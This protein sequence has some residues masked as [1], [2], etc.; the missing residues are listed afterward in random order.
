MHEIFTPPF[1]RLLKS[2]FFS[3]LLLSDFSA[4]NAQNA[5]RFNNWYF[6]NNAGVSFATG[7]PVALTNG[8]LVTTEGC[9]S[10]S[11][12]NGNL[13][14]YTDGVTV[15]NRNHVAMTNGTGL[16]GHASTTQSAIIVQRPGSTNLYYI[17]TA[18]ADAGVNGIKYSEVN[19]TLSGGLGAVTANKNIALRTP[20]SEKLTAVR[21]CNNTDLWIVSHDWNSNNF[22]TWLVT[23][24][25][26]NTTPIVS[27]AGVMA[28]GVSQGSYGQLKANPDGNKLLACYYGL[29]SGGVNRME[30]YDFNNSTGVVSNALTLASDVGLYG[31][32]FSPNGRMVYGG[33]NQG[34]LLQFNL[35]A[36]SN[37]AI[38]ASRFVLGNLGPFIGSMQLGPDNKVYV[39][40]NQTSLSVINNP[41]TAGAGCGYSNASISLAGRSSRM[42]LPN[43]ASF[44]IRPDVLTFTTAANCLDVNFTAPSVATSTNSCSGAASAIQ[45]VQ[46]NFGDPASGASNTSTAL[47]PSHTFSSM[48]A[49][50]VRLV[51]NLGCYNDT[52]IQTVNVSGFT[53]NTSTTPA[54][55]G[56]SNGTATASPAVAG[57]YTYLWSNGQQTAT[58]TGL[59]AGN[60]SCSVTASSGCISTVNVTVTA[61]GTMNV[62]VN[63]TNAACFGGNGSA[64]ASASGGTAPYSYSWSN[65]ANGATATLPA[66]NY[67]VTVS[68]AAGCV[69]NQNVTITAPAQLS[70]A[71]T[72]NSPLCSG[73]SGSAS[74]AVSGG[75]APYSYAWSNGSI[76]SSINLLTTG[77]Y[78]VTV[79]DARGCTASSSGTITIPTAL[80]ATLSTSNPWC[81]GGSNG[82]ASVSVNGGTSPYS[83][84]WSTGA[85]G[86]SIINQPAGAVLVSITDA[87]GC[88]IV[89]NGTLTAPAQ[90]QASVSVTPPACGQS[91]GSASASASGGSAPYT[92]VWSTG[93]F[94]NQLNGIAA[95]NYSLTVTDNAGC[96]DIENFS[97]S[98]SA[99]PS[100]TLTVTQQVSC[101]GGNNGEAQVS[102]NGGTAPYTYQWSNGASSATAQ[103]LS[104]GNYS[105]TIEDANGCAASANISISEPSEFQISLSSTNI[106]CNGL[107]NGTAAVT[108]NG[109]T[110]PYSF[111][112]NNSETT[113][114]ISG[115]P[116][117]VYSVIA[118]DAAGCVSKDSVSIVE[119]TPLQVL[120][121]STQITCNGASNGTVLLTISGA[122]APYSVIWNDG[123]NQLQRSGLD[124]GQY[125]YTVSDAVGCEQSG[126]ELITEPNLLSVSGI[127]A[128]LRCYGSNDGSIELQI[129]GGTQP[130]AVN[131]NSGQTT[132]TIANLDNGN[133]SAAI[134][135]ASGCEV[136]Y[137]VTI[138]EPEIIAFTSEVTPSSCIT[139]DGSIS[140]TATGGTAPYEY[141][142][143]G[144]PYQAAS[145]FNNLTA[146]NHSIS[147]RDA[148]GCELEE[149]VVVPSPAN[150]SLTVVQTTDVTCPGA[151]DG[152]AELE[153][154]GGTAPFMIS[155]SSEEATLTASM[156]SAGTHYVTVTDAAGCD[157]TTTFEIGEPQP[158]LATAAITDVRCFGG[159]DGA[160]ALNLEGGTGAIQISWEN[161]SNAAQINALAAG[162][163]A[164]E[165]TDANGC[166]VRDTFSVNQPLQA[167]AVAADIIAPGCG[168]DG[169]TIAL[170]V[171]GGTAPYTYAWSHDANLNGPLAGNLPVG[172]YS[173]TIEDANQCS[174]NDFY[175][176]ESP[177][178]LTAQIDS[179]F[180]VSCFGGNDGEVFMTVSG[181]T[182]PYLYN[183]G[184]GDQSEISTLAAGTYTMEISDAAGCEQV[185]NFNIS[186]PIA[187]LVALS[188]EDASCYGV[189]DGRVLA[190]VQGGAQP[191]AYDWS[192]NISLA[193]NENLAAGTYS[194]VVSDANG[195][196]AEAT[197]VVNQPD[198]LLVA[199][200]SENPG[201][202]SNNTG[203]ITASVSGGTGFYTYLW[204]TGSTSN[205]IAGLSSGT[206]EVQVSDANACSAQA[207]VT[208]VSGAAFSVF[209]DG[210]TS[211]CK[212][213]LTVLTATS[214]LPHTGYSISWGHGVNTENVEVN[215][216]DDELFTVV[217]TDSLGCSASASAMVHV[218]PIPAI[219]IA[220][221][222]ME[223]CAPVCTKF[224]APVGAEVYNWTFT[225]GRT[226]QGVDPTLCFENAGIYGVSLSVIDSNGCAAQMTWSETIEVF[227][228]PVA[229]FTANPSDV[230]LDDP[231]VNF[232]SQ[233]AGAVSY[234]Y[235][236]GD[237]ANNYVMSP[238][239]QHAYSDTGSFEVTLLVTNEHG[240]KDDAMRTI[241]VGGF[242]AFYIPNAFSPDGDGTNDVFMPKASGLASNG[243][244]MQIFDRWGNLIFVS[245]DWDKGWDGTYL[246]KEVQ[247]GQ[248]VCKVRYF[249]PK[250]EPTDQIGSVILT[251]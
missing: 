250:G 223:G 230:S 5:A 35:C 13:L 27:A 45:S 217:F 171:I 33:T 181:G 56:A 30:A 150:L 159:N 245:T 97:I 59:A 229:A 115:L 142:I 228:T 23:S 4:L 222:V 183:W 155:W 148:A 202:N 129:E 137:A 186:Q 60:Y 157:F 91:N 246:G 78:S 110:S 134:E 169:G 125:A 141:S 163:F 112:W 154:N 133:Y 72:A 12:L 149:I 7:S 184:V 241:H 10:I 108:A 213:E 214:N 62:N 38:V 206:Y 168:I 28:T 199:L 75:T 40:R 106:T 215:P 198:A 156:L 3:F 32:E 182:A 190:D 128:N 238:T 212:G 89:R 123:N 240:C 192:N 29:S 90:V 203:S 85:I 139:S 39:A 176:L 69:A 120:S 96:S 178:P 37:A 61:G 20:S 140:L 166:L 63:A 208:L 41:N 73:S 124:A 1:F 66:G 247:S 235:Y 79:T 55:C 98:A 175:T 160:I 187:L 65:G 109:G 57:A 36:V 144:L 248:Y 130:Y 193:I 239:A 225:D 113:S 86:T 83:Y 6:G 231:M 126:S 151:Y 173:I 197:T 82:S 116:A 2:L 172:A 58:A 48:G 146:G 162:A 54:S 9:A 100:L 127:T 180:S 31:C 122:Q 118:T 220:S 107:N 227:A 68:D 44:Y 170:D 242:T 207:E 76:L 209:I 132:T 105:V 34:L 131:W 80:N 102:V 26:V 70:A 161:G 136:T 177:A 8:A 119:P 188:A 152:T 25:G 52:L 224:E 111:A 50:S 64:T 179:V 104:A 42:G 226:A 121:T 195:C 18:D 145:V 147:I 221:S 204:N 164:L 243:Y 67:T 174:L 92:Y 200:V 189:N 22:R 114:S 236:F 93:T 11:D 165:L 210:D 19:M 244:E 81:F 71:V 17:F 49:F 158:M 185:L 21:H 15:W 74:V 191:Y 201:C 16:H 219:G 94:S 205:E 196:E 249:N 88:S 95:G 77:N 232:N 251:D 218:N 53:V 211:I 87:N 167:L 194:L 47:N 135:D 117:G 153:I 233:S 216:A 237:P 51:L 103:N 43:M 99:T 24:A 234:T 101:N 138:T 46:W 84:A 143:N 14:F